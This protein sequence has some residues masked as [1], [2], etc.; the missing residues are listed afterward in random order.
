MHRRSRLGPLAALCVAL[1]ACSSSVKV[2]PF[3][4]ADDGSCDVV[5]DAWPAT[6]AGQTPRVTAVQSSSVA[7]WGD[8]AI[9]ARCGAPILGPTTDQCLDINGVDWVATELDDG[10]KFTTYGRSPALEVLVPQ[11]Y[12]PQALL[13]PAFTDVAQLMDPGERMCS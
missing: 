2:A 4:G 1:T 11:D 3:E 6:V 12:E 13:M 9:I 8:P 5:A 7:A 10:I